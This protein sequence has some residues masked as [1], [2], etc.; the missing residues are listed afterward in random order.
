MG[1]N[2]HVRRALMMGGLWALE[3]VIAVSVSFAAVDRVASGVTSGDAARLSQEA[4]NDELR[5][6][7]SGTATSST[8]PKSTSAST[9]TTL[10]P[11]VTTTSTVVPSPTP[12][13]TTP[14]PPTTHTPPTT[15]FLPTTQTTTSTSIP[16]ASSNT[17]TTSE[18]G[19]LFTRCSGADQIVFVAAVPKPGYQRTVDNEDPGGVRQ[20]FQNGTHLSK[21]EAECSNGIVQAQVEEDSTDG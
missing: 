3:V 19:T 7:A 13:T 17:V 12:F 20:S 21:I 14:T 5:L 9:S 10:A 1:H 4:I 8:V 15:R 11:S 16:A 6:T 2:L 18:G